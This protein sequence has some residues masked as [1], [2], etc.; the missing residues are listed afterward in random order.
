MVL[1]GVGG[2]GAEDFYVLGGELGD[3]YAAAVEGD[4]VTI[5][6]SLCGEVVLVAKV[7]AVEVRGESGGVGE[8]VCGEPEHGA[9]PAVAAL[10]AFVA[11]GGWGWGVVGAGA[12]I[13]VVGIGVIFIVHGEA[14]LGVGLLVNWFECFWL[15]LGA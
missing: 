8:A 11:W 4:G 2:G 14:S 3:L 7:V 5:G 1:E 6:S 10:D 15:G 12:G 13:D 9:G